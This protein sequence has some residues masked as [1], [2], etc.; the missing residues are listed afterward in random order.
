MQKKMHNIL[1]V[2]N[3]LQIKTLLPTLIVIPLGLSLATVFCLFPVI[4]QGTSKIMI[5]ALI[6]V[7]TIADLYLYFLYQ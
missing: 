3:G 7:V 6:K 1:G 4:G 5:A 2:L